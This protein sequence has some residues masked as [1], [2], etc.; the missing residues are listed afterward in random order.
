ML[1]VLVA[2]R[3]Q[4]KLDVW[5]SRIQVSAGILRRQS[6]PREF[7]RSVFYWHKLG[8]ANS[9]GRYSTGENWVMRI[10]EVSILLAQT[11]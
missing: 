6:G 4:I 10:S 1:N 2:Y 9:R 5:A 3:P 8:N 7:T 11:G